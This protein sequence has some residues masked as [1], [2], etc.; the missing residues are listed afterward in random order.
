MY[1]YGG[2]FQFAFSGPIVKRLN[3][4]VN[5]LEYIRADIELILGQGVKHK[6]IIRV[7]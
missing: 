5:M 2:D 7:R 3:V 6:R 1:A 4:A